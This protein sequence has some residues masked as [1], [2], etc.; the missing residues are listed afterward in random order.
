[1][2]FLRK[3]PGFVP[4]EKI[5]NRVQNL[6]SPELVI[7]ADTLA[8]QVGHAVTRPRLDKFEL[9]QARE[10]AEGLLAVLDECIERL[11]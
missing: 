8:S 6:S 7:M 9:L 10:N 2:G 5:R 1:M 11:T 4:A 3:A